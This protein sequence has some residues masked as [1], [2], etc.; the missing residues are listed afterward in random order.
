MC[1]A[2]TW[3]WR[4]VGLIGQT[5]GR[6]GRRRAY[7]LSLCRQPQRLPASCARSPSELLFKI[8]EPLATTTPSNMVRLP[9]AIAVFHLEY[10][11]KRTALDSCAHNRC[12]SRS[13]TNWIFPL[14]LEGEPDTGNQ[15]VFR[16]F[17]PNAQGSVTC[18]APLAAR[19]QKT[20]LCATTRA[21]PRPQDW[22]RSPSRRPRSPRPCR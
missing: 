20:G 2:Y 19:K 12:R 10:S 15:P 17:A 14:A 1:H 3:P 9:P 18:G 4:R 6:R 22:I 5:S 8:D 16:S 11:S 13:Q 21:K 7:R